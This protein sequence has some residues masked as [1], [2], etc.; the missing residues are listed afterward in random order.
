[1]LD[2]ES[3]CTAGL[4]PEA[5]SEDTRHSLKSLLNDCLLFC[6]MCVTFRIRAF[7]I[8]FLTSDTEKSIVL[9]TRRVVPKRKF[10]T[11]NH[12]EVFLVLISHLGFR[13]IHVDMFGT[14]FV[15]IGVY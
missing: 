12:F 6:N 8:P 13:P 11:D 5:D 15:S 2:N 7:T 3:A 10:L 14:Q 9:Q 1:M 4:H